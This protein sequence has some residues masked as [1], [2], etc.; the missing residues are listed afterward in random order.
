MSKPLPP[1]VTKSL[2]LAAVLLPSLAYG[3]ASHLVI[4]QVYGGGGGTTATTTYTYNTDYIELYN[5]TSAA[6]DLTGLSLQYGSAAGNFGAS[7]SNIKVLSGT[8]AAHG[9]YLVSGNS[10]SVGGTLPTADATSSLSLSATAGKVA[11][12]NGTTSISSLGSTLR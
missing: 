7:A 2:A 8:V 10:G 9:Y 12:V 6:I 11:L 4:S 5:P 3:Q 1:S